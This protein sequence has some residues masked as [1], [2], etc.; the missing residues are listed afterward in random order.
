ML[1]LADAFRARLR[2]GMTV[3]LG[4]GVGVAGRLPDGTSVCAEL[5]S[6]AAEIGG[7]RLVVGWLPEP[8]VGLD[9]SA[10]AELIVLMPGAGARPLIRS[11]TTRF[12]PARF[13]A[14]PALLADRLR[15]Q[16][17]I[18]RLV[19]RA[20]ALHFGSE[21]SYQRALVD[22]G[23]SVLAVIDEATTMAS[24]EPPL[25]PDQVEIIGRS[26]AG[27]VRHHR[28]PDPVHEALA[29][30][31]LRFIP[32]DARIQYGPGQLGTALLRRAKVPLHV[33]TGLVTDAVV[34]LD[35]RGLLRGTPSAT[36]LTGTER[37]YDWAEGRPIL[38]GV[39]YTHDLT[40]L[41]RGIPFVAVNTAVE[42]DH[43]GQVNVEGQGDKVIGGIGG[44]P[45]FCAAA[46]MHPRGLSI[47]A[48]PSM[49]NGRSPLVQQLSRPVSTPAGDVD[50]IVTENGHAD[51]RD[52]DWPLR[53]R[54]IAELFGV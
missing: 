8:A 23:V 54:R 4:D 32:A 30:A 34:E 28:E 12:V 47:I 9:A 6:A 15:P 2:P 11:E 21:V 29:D 40:R 3:A 48:T 16:L 53:R 26:C 19:E 22:D 31:V 17:L 43:V 45:D 10:F 44:H 36:Y 27:P 25:N 7:I 35:R 38:R 51:L 14:W 42:I 1:A 37:L 49:V 18:T 39:Q 52:A 33:D 46:R 20:G 24:A 41:S 5:C 13:S 50:L